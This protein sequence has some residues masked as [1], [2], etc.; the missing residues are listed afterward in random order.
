MERAV[1][2]PIYLGIRHC[3]VYKSK[4]IH[5]VGLNVWRYAKGFKHIANRHAGID[6][7]AI[8]PPNIVY[9]TIPFVLRV[10]QRRAYR[11]PLS[12]YWG[13][14]FHHFIEFSEC[15]DGHPCCV[16]VEHEQFIFHARRCHEMTS[17]V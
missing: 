3:A 6:I 11:R 15:L 10:A 17:V 8:L 9:E 14:L 2:D 7:L 5:I 4:A 13:A 12:T 1:V 16:F